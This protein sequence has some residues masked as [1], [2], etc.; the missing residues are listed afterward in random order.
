METQN[1]GIVKTEIIP[2]TILEAMSEE[3]LLASIP[4]IT[5]ATE[6]VK[7]APEKKPARVS[8]RPYIEDVK[9]LL[10][11]G[12]HDKKEIVAFV[13]DKYPETKKS[14]IETFV[15]DLKNIK[16]SQF[17]PRVAIIHPITQKL[18]FSDKRTITQ[19]EPEAKVE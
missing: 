17:K 6:E 3:E 1:V 15:T 19:A 4:G 7:P 9:E 2:A 16:Y 12:T 8:K 18:I 10:E 13:L 14:G 11:A 5:V